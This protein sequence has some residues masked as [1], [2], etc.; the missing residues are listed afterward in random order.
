MFCGILLLGY[1]GASARLAGAA[2]GETGDV[3][4]PVAEESA[5]AVPAMEWL[6][7]SFKPDMYSP[8]GTTSHHSISSTV[9]PELASVATYRLEIPPRVR[10]PILVEKR[11][12]AVA[13]AD[14]ELEVEVV[15]EALSDGEVRANPKTG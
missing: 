9:K 1:T 5:V 15:T 14:E 4:L 7:D 11:D 13:E 6:V 10:E 2:V 8:K 12:V 3:L